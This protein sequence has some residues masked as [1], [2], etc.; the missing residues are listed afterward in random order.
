M[1]VEFG[2]YNLTIKKENGKSY[3]YDIIRKKWIVLTAEEQVRQVWIHYLV[4]D[5]NV[6]PSKIA[7]EKGFKIN[8]RVKRFDICVFGQTSCPEFIIECK[9]PSIKLDENSLN[10]ISIY[11]IKLNCKK[12][13]ISNG[14]SHRG[15]VVM[16]NEIRETVTIN[17][18]LG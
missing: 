18:F 9:S 16:E 14:I 8:D 7:I 10:Q 6:S 3:A 12:L 13:I 5:L 15:F 1:N 11:N 17:E 4:F 2:N